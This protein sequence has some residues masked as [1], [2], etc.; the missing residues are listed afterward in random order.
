MNNFL[1]KVGLQHV[2]EKIKGLLSGYL[3]LQKGGTIGTGAPTTTLKAGNITLEG[4]GGK[5]PNPG[6]SIKKKVEIS[7]KSITGTSSDETD[8]TFQI[9]NSGITAKKFV[10]SGNSIRGGLIANDSTTV[11]PG[12]EAID[13]YKLFYHSYDGD[14][15]YLG[16]YVVP[17]TFS[18]IDLNNIQMFIT[19]T[20]DT[21]AVPAYQNYICNL[22]IRIK[23]PK[24]TNFYLGKDLWQIS[25]PEYVESIV[26]KG[27]CAV[28][29]DRYTNLKTFKSSGAYIQ[30]E[31]S[32]SR[33]FYND[34]NL[35]YVDINDLVINTA[36]SSQSMFYSCS[37]LSNITLNNW[38]T[39]NI[40]D[41][42][43]MFAQCSSLENLDITGW[44]MTNVTNM[45]DMFAGCSKIKNLLL[46][47]GFGRMKDEVGTLD[48]SS[49]TNWTNE[50]VQ[51]LLTLYDRNANGL[52]VITIKLSTA[53][54]EALGTSG[55][56]T[57]T[58]KGYTIA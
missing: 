57:L 39:R 10:L 46:S 19:T 41:T 38:D 11:I 15:K 52:G 17:G 49:L 58:T 2:I 32:L 22:N 54:K 30:N 28:S 29:C 37:A 43:N 33:F 8:P 7:E 50:S 40:V 13:C 23:I 21:E 47:E 4:V 25:N 12:V 3:P 20:Q 36:T 56:Q 9:N 53:T 45:T 5:A 16:E 26:V 24:N 18:L 31:V 51:T 42:S 14:H 6:T 44:N 35:T 1:D 27:Q 34:K 48:L 55:I